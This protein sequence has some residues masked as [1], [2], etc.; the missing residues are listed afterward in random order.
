MTIPGPNPE[1]RCANCGAPTETVRGHY[2]EACHYRL[3]ETSYAEQ[4][5]AR[6]ELVQL[7]ERSYQD[8]RRRRLVGEDG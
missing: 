6:A 8:W 4:Q 2:C 5:T 3:F 7:A 1:R